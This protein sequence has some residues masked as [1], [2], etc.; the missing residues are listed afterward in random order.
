[1]VTPFRRLVRLKI[2]KVFRL[3]VVR[4]QLRFRR[5]ACNNSQLLRCATASTLWGY[6]GGGSA[7]C[8]LGCT[9]WCS[10]LFVDDDLLAC[11]TRYSKTLF[12]RVFG[13]FRFKRCSGGGRTGG[14]R[15]ASDAAASASTGSGSSSISTSTSDVSSAGSWS[16]LA[17]GSAGLSSCSGSGAPAAA[18]PA[19]GLRPRRCACAVAMWASS[20]GAYSA[21]L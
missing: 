13:L 6:L 2:R 9:L 15:G 12:H 7:S 19:A 5:V 20:P 11:L 17:T 16:G 4:W 3:V 21:S 8:A 10:E 18:P 1:M 14:G